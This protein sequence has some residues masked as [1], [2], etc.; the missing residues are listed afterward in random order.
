M[1]RGAGRKGLT[2]RLQPTSEQQKTPRELRPARRPGP[3]DHSVEERALSPLREQPS[4]AHW[5][6]TL[7]L[8]ALR[9]RCCK[10]R[11]TISVRGC[12][13][14]ETGLQPDPHINDHTSAALWF[15]HS[16]QMPCPSESSVEGKSP[17]NQ[18][19]R[20]A[21]SKAQQPK[22]QP[23]MADPGHPGLCGKV[24]MVHVLPLPQPPG[25]HH[26][27]IPVLRGL[28]SGWKSP[29]VSMNFLQTV[30]ERYSP[31]RNK[32]IH[33]FTK[34][35]HVQIHVLRALAPTDPLANAHEGRQTGKEHL[36]APPFPFRNIAPYQ[37]KEHRMH[38][39][40]IMGIR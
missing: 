33:H 36:L 35:L 20:W 14:R 38:N 1:P 15:A 32:E 16:R 23:A 34:H 17:R 18:Q 27:Q 37:Y 19:R 31:Q 40:I 29:P 5:S 4:S 22:A 11:E 24:S 12:S 8:L 10:R 6:W 25:Q 13:D 30:K 21:F 26:S 3:G 2:N 7:A 28:G 39:I 9:D